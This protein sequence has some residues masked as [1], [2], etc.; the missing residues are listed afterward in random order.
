MRRLTRNTVPVVVGAPNTAP[1]PVVTN[2]VAGGLLFALAA[3]YLARYGISA[4]A[5][6]AAVGLLATV[7]TAVV[8]L[9]RLFSARGKV[10]LVENPM[11]ASGKPLV[12]TPPAEGGAF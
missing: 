4:D 8:G 3:A 2:G 7:L 11:S 5:L 9:W 12:E 10:T 1:G 6:H